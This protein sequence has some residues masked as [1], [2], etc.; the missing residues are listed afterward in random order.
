MN[1]EETNA[2]YRK[3]LTQAEIFCQNSESE[4]AIDILNEVISD[5]NSTDSKIA[6]ALTLKGITVDLAPYPS[7]YQQN[8]FALIYFQKALEYNPHNIYILF[9]ILSSFSC[10]DMMQKY[11]KKNKSAFINAYD[12]LKNDLYDT[13][14]EELKNDL[15]KFSSKYN[16]FREERFQAIP[17]RNHLIRAINQL[18][19]CYNGTTYNRL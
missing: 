18:T 12:V 16:K 14:N 19:D 17:Y 15:R 9:N 1:G 4:L 2:Q 6:E 11:T 7:E 5:I 13:L 10:I 8:Y 3:K